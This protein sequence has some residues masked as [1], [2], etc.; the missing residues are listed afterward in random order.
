MDVGILTFQ[1]ANNYGAVLQCYALQEY[2]ENR[3]NVNVCIINYNPTKMNS[4]RSRISG[5]IR[6]HRQYK[7]FDGFRKKHFHLKKNNKYDLIIVG[8]DQV[9]NPEIIGYDINW[10]S[11]PY[12][13]ERIATYAASMGKRVLSEQEINFFYENKNILEKYSGIA[14]RENDG[15]EILKKLGIKSEQVCDPVFLLFS[16]MDKYLALEKEA[17]CSV[18]G[19]Y[20]FVYSLEKNDEIDAIA[21]RIKQETGLPIISIHPANDMTQKADRFIKDTGPCDF[22]Y[23]IRHSSV[24]IT[25]SF[26]GLA[27]SIMFK[28]K[29][30]SVMHSAGLSSRQLQLK[31]LFKDYIIEEQSYF[32]IDHNQPYDM[33]INN[34][35]VEAEKYIS[36]LHV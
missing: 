18:V 31:E 24:V 12:R 4:Y 5:F 27:F 15:V 2:L 17:N 3:N 20:I 19:E 22:L 33:I 36:S 34:M 28:K 16:S 8:S 1:F 13:Y 25:N 9:W 35:I 21:A 6:H 14:I 23:L 26:H 10:I 11:P 29:V 7:A 32:Y 30:Y